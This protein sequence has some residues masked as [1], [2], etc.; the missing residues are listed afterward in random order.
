MGFTCV[1]VG[2]DTRFLTMGAAASGAARRDA[3]TPGD[4]S[5]PSCAETLPLPIAAYRSPLSRNVG[6]AGECHEP[7][8][9]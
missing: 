5:S 1:T 8:A 2:G 6:E 9:G 3:P 7:G 4:R